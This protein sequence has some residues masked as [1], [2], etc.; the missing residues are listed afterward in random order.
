MATTTNTS[1]TQ[2]PTGPSVLGP[3]DV[4]LLSNRVLSNKDL[5][6][7][8]FGGEVAEEIGDDLTNLARY[9]G[10]NLTLNL[11]RML[12][13]RLGRS[14]LQDR[15][16]IDHPA[17]V[18]SYINLHYMEHDQEVMGALFLDI[19]NCLITEK[20]IFRGCLAKTL[21]EPRQLFRHAI[22]SHAANILLFHTHPSGD[23]NPS[24]NDLD[25]TERL[26][27]VGDL[28]G[29]RVVDHLIV[30]NFGSWVSLKRRGAI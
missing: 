4:G 12:L 10:D 7:T 24:S 5:L 9:T 11:F 17:A 3:Q 8:F 27:K 23:V 26:C 20:L 15:P 6:A 21:V 29:I 25:L 28:L 13:T 1:T 19:R 14:Q 22:S 16:L 30:G 18:A 2:H